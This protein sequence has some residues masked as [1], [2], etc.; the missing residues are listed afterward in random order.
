MG[1]LIALVLFAGRALVAA[2]VPDAAPDDVSSASPPSSR[3]CMPIYAVF[4]GSA[5]GLRRFRTQAELRRRLL[6][7]E[8]DP[9]ARRC[10]FVWSVGGAFVGFVAAAALIIV[11]ASR[12]MRLPRGGEPFPMRRIAAL[13]GHR[14]RLHGAAEL[15]LNSDLLLLRWF[16]LSAPASTPM[17]PRR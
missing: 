4:I 15:P 16:A 13:H 17:P 7:D 9:A 8:D 10:A 5:N 12:V 3:C 11:I 2:I 14:R 1:L 6:D